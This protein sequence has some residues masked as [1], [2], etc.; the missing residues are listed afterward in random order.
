MAKKPMLKLQIPMA[1]C[2]C[3]GGVLVLRNALLILALDSV[4]GMRTTIPAQSMKRCSRVPCV[5][6]MV[7]HLHLPNQRVP[8]L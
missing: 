1:A 3:E 5:G 4:V 6:I 7:R 2:K 8:L